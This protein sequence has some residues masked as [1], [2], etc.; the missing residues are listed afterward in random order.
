MRQVA[1]AILLAGLSISAAIVY[2]A[3]QLPRYSIQE[4]SDGFDRL[5]VRSGR[6]EHC[7]PPNPLVPNNGADECWDAK[8]GE[9]TGR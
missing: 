5:D 2:A 9:V 3:S 7:G 6:V 1:L 8:K 4:T